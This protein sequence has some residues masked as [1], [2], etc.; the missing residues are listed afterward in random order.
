MKTSK[1]SKNICFCNNIAEIEGVDA[2]EYCSNHLKTISIDGKNWLTTY[3]C[4]VT[5]IQWLEDYPH[6]EYHGGGSPRLRRLPLNS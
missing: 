3:E 5:S 4:P 2:Q 6:S 1:Y